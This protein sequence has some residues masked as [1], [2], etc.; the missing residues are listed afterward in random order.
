MVIELFRDQISLKECA[1]YKWGLN[2]EH[3][4]A[5]QVHKLLIKLQV[6]PYTGQND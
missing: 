3:F 5:K 2:I 4:H 6:L 1:G